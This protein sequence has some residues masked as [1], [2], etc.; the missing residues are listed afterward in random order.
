MSKKFAAACI[1]AMWLVACEGSEETARTLDAAVS[2]PPQKRTTPPPR[3]VRAA[4]GGAMDAG[5]DAGAAPAVDGGKPAHVEQPDAGQH[6]VPDAGNA[7]QE[8][9]GP[10]APRC[11][12]GVTVR[13]S[14]SPTVWLVIDGS[15][16]MIDLFGSV[17]RWDALR[18]VLVNPNDGLIKSLQA[19]LRW[20]LV[21]FDGPLPGGGP[22]A[23]VLPDG[24]MIHFPSPPATTCPRTQEV[25]P[26]L[27]NF[28]A[29]QA[30]LPE[31]PLGGSTPTDKALEH[32][33]QRYPAAPASTEGP[34]S[35]VLATD[36]APNDFC[37]ESF[38][39][40]DVRPYVVN[41]VRKLLD[42]GIT[43]YTLSLAS[44]DQ[45]LMQHL[46]EVAANGGTGKP[47]FT[48]ADKDALASALREIVGKNVDCSV[49]LN[50]CVALSHACDGAVALD[51]KAVP[52][53]DQNG[54]SLHDEATLQLNGEACARYR[55]SKSR[56]IDI[57]YPCESVS[58]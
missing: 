37:S 28:A 1:G 55:A 34:V 41:A 19:E 42:R 29:L 50:K 52:C 25:E 15:G 47:V 45:N 9:G 58:R 16:S 51:G 43:T 24:G 46:T 26:Q 20:G 12:A 8:D 57:D 23:T 54:F 48:P 6:A 7:P 17:S 22:N 11:H 14:G 32:L 56:K 49:R 44:T 38:L 4:D 18:E 40:P 53:D 33:L 21:L 27:N 31:L 5:R 36:G 2:A 30:A 3:G 10:T 35:V 39:P 13:A